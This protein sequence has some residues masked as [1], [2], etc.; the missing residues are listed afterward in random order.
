MRVVGVC[1]QPGVLYLLEDLV[2]AA[3]S[4][5]GARRRVRAAGHA[6]DLDK[7]KEGGGGSGVAQAI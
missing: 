5:D 4:S 1:S 6:R 2:P 3:K 7:R